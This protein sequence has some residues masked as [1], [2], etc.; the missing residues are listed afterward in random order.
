MSDRGIECGYHSLMP[1]AEDTLEAG[2]G[3]T[4]TFHDELS[5]VFDV[6]WRIGEEYNAYSVSGRAVV[7]F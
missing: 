5:L 1:A 6:D 3:F 7:E 4:C 2:A